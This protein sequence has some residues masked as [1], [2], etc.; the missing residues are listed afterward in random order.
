MRCCL[1][2]VSGRTGGVSYLICGTPRTGSTLLC[3]LLQSTGMAGRPESYFRPPD[4]PMWARGW[5]V[6]V[7]PDGSFDYGDYVQAAIPAGSTENGV[8]GG[9]VMW[10]TLAAM[11]TELG[12]VYPH[13]APRDLD[14]LREAFG[15]LRFCHLRR[16]DTLAQAV[17]WPRAEQTRYWH[18]GDTLLREPRFDFQEIHHLVETIEA[19]NA[20]WQD[21]FAAF[22]IRPHQMIYEELAADMVGATRGVLDFLGLGAPADRA[23]VSG[24][25]RQA[26][27][28]NTDWITRYR[29]IAAQ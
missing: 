4:E 16:G 25:R 6:P 5:R 13:L 1:V 18:P 23:I 27:E 9:R 20:S 21:W 29:T 26:D 3:S 12:A 24:R 15:Q 2:P 17:S 28:L 11:V 10:G 8:F 22:D 7:G 19:H 14:L